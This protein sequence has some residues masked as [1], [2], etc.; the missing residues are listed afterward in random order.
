M[1]NRDLVY[2]NWFQ[3]LIIGMHISPACLFV[4][5]CCYFLHCYSMPVFSSFIELD[6]MTSTSS[7]FGNPCD[8]NFVSW[9]IY[10][11]DYPPPPIGRG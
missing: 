6:S 4:S 1:E 5:M 2:E 10:N 8:R 11:M 3:V 9:M 7:C